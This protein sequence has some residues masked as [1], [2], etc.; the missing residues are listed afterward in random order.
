VRSDR[1]VS[2]IERWDH[3]AAR[4]RFELVDRTPIVVNR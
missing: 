4:E 2:A 3:D 1:G